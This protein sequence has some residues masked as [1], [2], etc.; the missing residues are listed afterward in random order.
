M[1][2]VY[3]RHFL[4]AAIVLAIGVGVLAIISMKM[5]KEAPEPPAF[6]ADDW[7]PKGVVPLPLLGSVDLTT[8]DRMEIPVQPTATPAEFDSAAALSR[9]TWKVIV[10]GQYRPRADRTFPQD[11]RLLEYMSAL[12]SALT[13]AGQP[14]EV[15][16]MR[17]NRP[18]MKNQWVNRPMLSKCGSDG[19]GC[20][21]EYLVLAQSSLDYSLERDYLSGLREGCRVDE[22][23]F[24]HAL[25]IVDDRGQMRQ[26]YTPCY[27]PVSL[28]VLL[29][30]FDHHTDAVI[31]E[32]DLLASQAEAPY[33]TGFTLKPSVKDDLKL[34]GRR[35]VRQVVTMAGEATEGAK[36]S[37]DEAVK[38]WSK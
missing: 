34:Q 10:I 18:F 14:T 17:L 2:I 16:F 35:L 28:N 32:N 29:Q 3:L 11:N 19:S 26:A 21:D 27:M 20:F 36:D 9:D 23:S 4:S 8:T 6:V 22:Y 37:Y 38:K 25:V 24:G 7:T 12:K 1:K 15:W 13:G 33:L 30:N 31:P 5:E